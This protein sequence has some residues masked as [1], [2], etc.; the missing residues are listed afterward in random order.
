M[1]ARSVAIGFFYFLECFRYGLSISGE[2]RIINGN[3]ADINS[4]PYIVSL[5]NN[6]EHMCGGSILNENWIV[7]AAHCV[8]IVNTPLKEM[9]LCSGTS[10]LNE[11]CNLHYVEKYEIHPNYDDATKDYDIALIRVTPAFTFSDNTSPIDLPSNANI[12]NEWATV[13]G[14]GYYM[15][16]NNQVKTVVSNQLKCA[17]VPWVS[18]QQ[19]EMNYENIQLTSRMI[20]YGYQTGDVDACQ[21][22][23]GGPL[24]NRDNILIGII[25]WGIGCADVNAPGVYTDVTLFLNWIKDIIRM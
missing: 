20:C 8:K 13:C 12:Y 15:K 25:S 9:T 19:C 5:K 24:I 3:D 11:N 23:S 7:T 4:Y 10:V 16:E 17:T 21:G 18:N 14:W 2:E 1:N 6:G 22:D